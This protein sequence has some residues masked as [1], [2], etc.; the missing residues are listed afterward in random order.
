MP[1][2]NNGIVWQA[3]KKE[4]NE[5]QTKTSAE[6]KLKFQSNTEN[7]DLLTIKSSGNVNMFTLDSG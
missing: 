4:H 3:D 2:K 6:S 1:S 7:R 5:K